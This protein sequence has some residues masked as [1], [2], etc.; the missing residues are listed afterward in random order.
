MLQWNKSCV[1]KQWHDV[2]RGHPCRNMNNIPLS[3]RERERER[4]RK[5]KESFM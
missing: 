1:L 2:R 3:E 4:E 5:R